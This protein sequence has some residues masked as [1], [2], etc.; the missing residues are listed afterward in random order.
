MQARALRHG[1]PECSSWE[2]AGSSPRP[3]VPSPNP[4]PLVAIH[5]AV[6][7]SPPIQTPSVRHHAQMGNSSGGADHIH[8]PPHPPSPATRDPLEGHPMYGSIG[9]RGG[10][11]GTSSRLS[12]ISLVSGAGGGGHTPQFVLFV[13]A[14]NCHFINWYNRDWGIPISVACLMVHA[15]DWRQSFLRINRAPRSS[16]CGWESTWNWTISTGG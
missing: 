2:G 3:A 12:F 8:A 9:E 15:N 7:R 13:G 10:Y 14:L 5:W 6:P 4:T 1:I 11:Q 16:N